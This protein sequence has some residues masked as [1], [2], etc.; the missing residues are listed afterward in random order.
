[1]TFYVK[2]RSPGG[3]SAET[4]GGTERLYSCETVEVV[5]S[6]P[7]D[8]YNDGIFLDRDPAPL[9][10]KDSES[11]RGAKHIILFGGEETDSRKRRKGG[12]VWVMSEA[13]STVAT[14]DL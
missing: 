3:N 13:G 2:E 11:P 14:Y 8:M 1:M 9:D 10:P 6:F 4:S 5:R 7:P 12:K